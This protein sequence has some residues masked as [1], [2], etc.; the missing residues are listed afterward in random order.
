MLWGPA[1]L[2]SR[3]LLSSKLEEVTSSL[4][5]GL[6]IYKMGWQHYYRSKRLSGLNRMIYVK[7]LHRAWHLVNKN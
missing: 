1:D 7:G 2:G 3:P 4:S 5:L 6:L